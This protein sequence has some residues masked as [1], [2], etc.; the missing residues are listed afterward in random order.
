MHVLWN[1]CASAGP[2][3]P[4]VPRPRLFHNFGGYGEVEWDYNE[5]LSFS[6]RSDILT[7]TKQLYYLFSMET[8]KN[9][10]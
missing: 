10:N 3:Q 2:L 5:I 4:Q 1:R 6:F 7:E 8:G 9:K